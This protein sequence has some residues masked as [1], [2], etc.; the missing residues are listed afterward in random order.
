LGTAEFFG[1]DLLHTPLRAGFEKRRLVGDGDMQVIAAT[2]DHVATAE[3]PL[4]VHPGWTVIDRIDIAN[5]ASE[6]AHGWRGELGRRKFADPTA[7]W[8]FVGREVG[9][10]GLLLDGGR[11]IRGGGERFTIDPGDRSR[12]SRLVIRTGGE[13]AYPYQDT[14]TRPVE[15]VLHDA[16]GRVIAR[17][18][19]PAP[20]GAQVEIAFDLPAGTS[21]VQVTAAAP[22]RVFHW[23]VLQQDR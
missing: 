8:S 21:S 7:K 6:R 14:L 4:G 19:L 3:R 11:T 16:T 17:A 5:L 9:E 2:W 12:P 22:Y 15:L 23:F 20:A 13:R 18:T 10:H 1:K